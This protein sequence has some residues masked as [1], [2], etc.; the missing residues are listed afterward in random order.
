MKYEQLKKEFKELV[1]GNLPLRLKIAVDLNKGERTIY[2]WMKSE[3]PVV[4][5]N[6]V[7]TAF[8][9]ALRTHANISD[10]V[11]LTELVEMEVHP[12]V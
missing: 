12:A 6:T 5:A 4:I 8:I 2:N 9:T 3:N 1:L 10:K 7:S 11:Q